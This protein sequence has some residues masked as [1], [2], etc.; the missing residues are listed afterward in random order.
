MTKTNLAIAL[1]IG[2]LLPQ[3]GLAKENPFA[4]PSTLP[5]EA[6]PFDKACNR[7]RN[8]DASSEHCGEAC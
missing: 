1:C 4:K 2:A 8:P 6:P 5:Y 3:A 7:I